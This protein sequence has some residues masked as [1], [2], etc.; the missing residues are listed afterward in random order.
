MNLENQQ[1]KQST[2]STASVKENLSELDS[3]EW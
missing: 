3:P 2:E 1:R